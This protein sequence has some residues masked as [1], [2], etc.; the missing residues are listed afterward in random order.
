MAPGAGSGIMGAMRTLRPGSLSQPWSGIRLPGRP[1]ARRLMPRLA[2]LALLPV[3]LVLAGC[4]A[5]APAGTPPITPGTGAA[6]RDVNIVAHEY[7]YSPPVV[8]LVPGET[9]TLHVVNGGLETHEAVFG[10]LDA[11]LVWEAAE[12]ATVDHPPGPTPVVSVPPGFDGVRIVVGSGQRVDVTWTVP[13]DAAATASGW[14]V[15]CHIPGHWQKGMVVPV[16][17][18]DAGGH[19]LASVPALPGASAAP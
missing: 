19:V 16:R 14:F 11:Q 5:S 2:A 1:P 17:F 10:T 3:A 15:G 7:G 6:P 12:S 18:V 4:D 9:V 8:D 13:A